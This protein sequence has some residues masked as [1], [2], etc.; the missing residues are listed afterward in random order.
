[1]IDRFQMAYYPSFGSGTVVSPN[2][3]TTMNRRKFLL[4]ASALVLTLKLLPTN[5]AL[6]ELSGEHSAFPGIPYDELVRIN[7]AFCVLERLQFGPLAQ[8][9]NFGIDP[10]TVTDVERPITALRTAV[11]ERAIEDRNAATR[12]SIGYIE[13]IQRKLLAHVG[14]DLDAQLHWLFVAPK[15]WGFEVSFYEMLEIGTLENQRFT[16][17]NI[18]GEPA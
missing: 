18:T 14:P 5:S 8:A 9:R 13:D 12:K 16:A 7:D 10:D 2:K 4:S 15:I 11:V 1:M 6:A 3:E 17:W